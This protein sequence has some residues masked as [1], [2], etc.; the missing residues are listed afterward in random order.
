MR[1]DLTQFRFYPKQMP[2]F[3]EDITVRPQQGTWP[4]FLLIPLLLMAFAIGMVQ[5]EISFLWWGPVSILFLIVL[6]YYLILRPVEVKFRAS[7]NEVNIVYRFGWLT[8]KGRTFAF[9]DVESIQSCFKVTG[10][11]DPEVSLEL[12][13][14]TQE[15]LILMS[16]V[17]NWSPSAPLLG[18]SGC[19]EPQKMEVLRKQISS[20]TGIKDLGF[21]R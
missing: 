2:P 19:L 3:H 5:K 1:Y 14:K 13:L 17:P 21:L 20:I 10:D 6:M 8:R 11:N 4:F 18:Y 12:T 7:C 9:D 15:R 16:A